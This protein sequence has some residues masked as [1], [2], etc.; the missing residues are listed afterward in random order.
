MT[1]LTIISKIGKNSHITLPIYQNDDDRI[2]FYNWTLTGTTILKSSEWKK[3]FKFVGYKG[4]YYF[5]GPKSF[6]L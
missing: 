6:G 4:D 2:K 5:S 3:L 1:I